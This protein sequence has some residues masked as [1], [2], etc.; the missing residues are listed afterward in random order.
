EHAQFSHAP[1]APGGAGRSAGTG[2]RVCEGP[3]SHSRQRPAAVG[4]PARPGCGGA[5]SRRCGRGG[6]A[7]VLR[8]SGPEP[9]RGRAALST[10]ADGRRAGHSDRPIEAESA[11]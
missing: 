2:S 9:G 11:R 7:G 5:V 8:A 10:R 4:G 3:K 6:G 1:G